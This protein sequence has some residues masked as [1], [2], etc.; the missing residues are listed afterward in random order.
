MAFL[1]L[2]KIKLF[3]KTRVVWL[4]F[5]LLF[6]FFV[7]FVIFKITNN[8]Y[9]KENVAD[10]SDKWSYYTDADK[11]ER[12]IHLPASIKE[13]HQGQSWY[14]TCILPNM[15]E[16][17]AIMFR[18][19]YSKVIIRLEEEEI[20]RFG[21]EKTPFATPGKKLIISRL[22]TDYSGKKLTITLIPTMNLRAYSIYMGGEA[23]LIAFAVG[24]SLPGLIVS[25]L[26]F[27]FGFTLLFFFILFINNENAQNGD[28]FFSLF[29][30]LT[31][32]FIPGKV[33]LIHML[34]SP[35]Q[36]TF[37]LMILSYLIPIAILLYILSTCTGYKI[38]VITALVIHSVCYLFFSIRQI[39]S[40]DSNTALLSVFTVI[41]PIYYLIALLAVIRET[42]RGNKEYNRLKWSVLF[43]IFGFVTDKVNTFSGN[44]MRFND[45]ET[46][47]KIGLFIFV[48][49]EVWIRISK[50]LKEKAQIYADYQTSQ[51]RNKLA[52]EHFDN[53]SQY[54]EKIQLLNHDINHHFHALHS[55]IDQ[56]ETARA[57]EY[58]YRLSQNYSIEEKIIYTENHLLNCI[59]TYALKESEKKE[60]NL[61]YD[62]HLPENIHMS[63]ND[64]Y[65]LYTNILDNALEACGAIENTDSRN[66]CFT[67]NIK[68]GFMHITCKNDKEN[69]ILIDN[70]KYLSTK[71]SDTKRGLG[72]HIIEKIVEKYH[73]V[74]DIDYGEDWFQIRLV[75]KA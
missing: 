16:N 29:V 49:I 6:L 7:V 61:S 4:L 14:L 31:G 39:I 5:S 12:P 74:M 33:F 25:F 72:I 43:V 69:A 54:M 13:G 53:I 41:Y 65:S 22:P 56:G 47:T 9:M 34:F 70:G 60:I 35:L 32:L 21:L 59:M 44:P 67:C 8:P 2:N 15:G 23:S 68:N 40:P 42:R 51:L 45:V 19:D 55:L 3:N 64:F 1:S 48:T 24:K 27:L 75:L 52:L 58:L 66:I 46:F 63:D 62:I 17:A 50:Y 38:P 36:L 11:T 37:I 71:S 73:G 30:I 18:S 28:L 57:R 26:T 20:Y 10:I